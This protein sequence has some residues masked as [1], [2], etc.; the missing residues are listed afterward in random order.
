MHRSAVRRTQ[1]NWRICGT[2]T[3]TKC[4]EITHR[5]N[6]SKRFAFV[7]SPWKK[8]D[9]PASEGRMALT[10]VTG[11][12][13]PG[14]SERRKQEG[15][16][17]PTTEEQIF[18]RAFFVPSNSSQERAGPLPPHKLF[19]DEE[20][21]LRVTKLPSGWRALRGDDPLSADQ[22]CFG[23]RCFS[24]LLISPLPPVVL[25]RASTL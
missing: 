21:M 22:I 14:R 8:L 3:F 19:R 2:I 9:F 7:A 13:T 5:S 18:P 17:A 15:I 11:A 23:R 1:E 25:R 4:N 12:S 24:V 20:T 6:P 16:D 10:C